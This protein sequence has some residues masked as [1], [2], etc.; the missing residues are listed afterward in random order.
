MMTP[1]VRTQPEMPWSSGIASCSGLDKHNLGVM[2]KDAAMVKVYRLHLLHAAKISVCTATVKPIFFGKIFT[3]P[4]NIIAIIIAIH[5][6]HPHF[7][8]Q[9]IQKLTC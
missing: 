9:P 1:E 8:G 2:T 7:C 5:I 3:L 6:Y 4:H